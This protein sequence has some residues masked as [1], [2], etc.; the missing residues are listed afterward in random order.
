[1]VK[2]AKYFTLAAVSIALISVYVKDMRWLGGFAVSSSWVA[3]NFLLYVALFDV[4]TSEKNSRKISVLLIL[5][6]PVLYLIG[7]FIIASKMFPAGSIFTGIILTS[8]VG[9]GVKLWPS[10]T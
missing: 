10:R 2:I 9:I 5:K 6:F 8:A 1:M 4:I 3:I 7:F